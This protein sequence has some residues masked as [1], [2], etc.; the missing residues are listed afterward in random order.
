MYKSIIDLFIDGLQY[1][2]DDL[3]PI[4][5]GL[6]I[7][8]A[9]GNWLGL[10]GYQPHSHQ[11]R[12]RDNYNLEKIKNCLPKL[13]GFTPHLEWN[14]RNGNEIDERIRSG[15]HA[16]FTMKG[17]NDED[18]IDSEKTINEYLHQEYSDKYCHDLCNYK[19]FKRIHKSY[20]DIYRKLTKYADF[21][22][23]KFD[24]L[25]HDSYREVKK[26]FEQRENI[27]Y[28][29]EDVIEEILFLYGF[30]LMMLQRCD[31]E[32]YKELQSKAFEKRKKDE[33]SDNVFSFLNSKLP[34][35]ADSSRNYA[36]S[37]F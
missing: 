35:T 11:I 3:A 32:K 33:H 22:Y 34:T 36:L 9:C 28:I 6:K 1:S 4:I 30:Y 10:E 19:D 13:D 15:A 17:L 14:L 25:L 23:H 5:A 7:E 27:N 16:Y 18:Y 29:S 31:V 24:D 2:D 12:L 21:I 26:G 20:Y 8:N 37:P